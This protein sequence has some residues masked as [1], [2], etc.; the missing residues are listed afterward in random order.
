ME[1][2]AAGDPV[3]VN[4]I[5]LRGR[6]GAG[7]MGQVF[8]GRSLGGRAVAVKLVHPHLARQAEFRSRFRRE[9]AAARAV[10]GAFTA[11]V[12]AAGPE[13]DP[14]WIATV[15]VPGPSLAEAVAVAGGLPAGSVW[16]LA[17]GLVEALQAIHAEGLL[18]RDLK[19]S[20]VLLAADGPRVIDFGI[21]RAMDTTA[22][23]EPG[24]TI[25]TPGFMSPE[26][27]E[28]GRVEQPSDVFAL[29]AV[30]AFAATGV[31]P[32]GQGEPLAVLLRV[33]N[34]EPQLDGLTDPL[35]A[36]VAACLAKN[37][38]DRPTTAQLLGQ[39]AAHWDP[40][41][42]FPLTSP[43][44]QAVTDLIQTHAISATAPYTAQATTPP[45][46]HSATTLTAP[47][48]HAPT[49]PRRRPSDTDHPVGL[50]GPVGDSE[51]KPRA[52]RRRHWR[53]IRLNRSGE[54]AEAARVLAD[55]IPDRA[56]AWGPDHSGTL[57]V[58]RHHALTVGEAGDHAE[59]ARLLAE[60]VPDM[61]RVLGPDDHYTLKV[62][63]E[64]ARELWYA[65][66]HSEA[67]RLLAEVIP[68][69]VR[70]RGPDHRVALRARRQHALIV[71]EAGEY[72]E[73]AR[74]LAD[75]VPHLVRVWGPDHP[76]TLDTRALH[77]NVLGRAGQHEEA[78][79]L[80]AELTTDR[81]RVLGPDDHLTLEIRRQH[82]LTVAEAGEHGEAARLLAGLVPD[83]VRVWGS[84][85]PDTLTVRHEHAWELGE[86]GEYAEAAR[87]YAELA[88]DR[89]RVLG[90]DHPDTLSARS[91]ADHWG[92]QERLG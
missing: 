76:D 54:F 38:A 53:A 12:V 45:S 56:R 20:N 9:V 19:P 75:L 13:D 10:S 18:H 40:P 15:Y 80:Y 7:G 48:R 71:A 63:H 35:R 6:L 66:D 47:P 52:L 14:P 79:R 4:G 65:G 82:A 28:G 41:D 31:R 26:Q 21:V 64:H 27:A 8:L 90:P 60:L 55:L 36:L 68:D 1:P 44:P 81:V 69:Y 73:A 70:L 83:L 51:P 25:G 59:A 58:R 34:G 11:P 5:V 22:L 42:D 50:V 17:A 3:R 84:D 88:T 46:Q 39:I 24:K 32:F 30:L 43:W 87:L 86:A 89:A 67:A 77:A 78:A 2:L 23:T 49:H 29:G 61:T 16:P 37:P 85:H 91:S 92:A 62:R 57:E 33:V 74:L 72:G